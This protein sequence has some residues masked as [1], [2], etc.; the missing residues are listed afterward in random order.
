LKKELI[1]SKKFNTKVTNSPINKLASKLNRYC[2][3]KEVQVTNKYMKKC[4]L[5]LAIKKM[6]I[7][8][9]LRVN[10]TPGRMAIINKTKS[11]NM[12]NM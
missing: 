12:L 6:Q 7:E 3:N 2:L 8:S 10:L 4:S 9:T 1:K 11:S 5:S